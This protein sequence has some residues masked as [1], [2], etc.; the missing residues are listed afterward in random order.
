MLFKKSIQIIEEFAL[1]MNQIFA[2]L[3]VKIFFSKRALFPLYKIDPVNFAIK[4]LLIWNEGKDVIF[5]LR[6]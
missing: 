5:L 6:M 2:R 4:V 3:L 1:L